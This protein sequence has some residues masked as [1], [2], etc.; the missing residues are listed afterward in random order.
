MSSPLTSLSSLDD[1]AD[2]PHND[3]G[4]N[5]EADELKIAEVRRNNI[6]RSRH[7]PIMVPIRQML[8]SL[9]IGRHLSSNVNGISRRKTVDRAVQTAS[10]TE[11]PIKA[12]GKAANTVA[13]TKVGPA[14]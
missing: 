3:A 14:R 8:C 1:F 4:L 6:R 12:R 5:E 10:E 7:F 11:I 2:D 9:K 13:Y